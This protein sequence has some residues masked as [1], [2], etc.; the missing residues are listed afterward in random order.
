MKSFVAIALVAPLLAAL[1]A[2]AKTGSHLPDDRTSVSPEAAAREFWRFSNCSAKRS[3]DGARVLLES[4]EWDEKMDE[5]VT[6]F[7]KKHRS[8]LPNGSKMR[9]QAELFRGSLAAAYL[10]QKYK[11]QPVPDYGSI[12]TT[13]TKTALDDL[14]NKSERALFMVRAFAECVVRTQTAL[15]LNLFASKP[16]S[17]QEKAIFGQLQPFMGACLPVENGDQV[18]FTAM[19][20]RGLMAEAAY[21][22]EMRYVAIQAIPIKEKTGAES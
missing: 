20:L 4:R 13:Y 22:V 19:S 3:M 17:K 14:G 6:A 15:A 16:T 8:C 12:P 21:D 10:T 11:K 9:F 7:T 2:Q 5:Q 18:K 1:P